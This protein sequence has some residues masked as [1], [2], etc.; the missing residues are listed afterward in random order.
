MLRS[1]SLRYVRDGVEQEIS[2]DSR[3]LR[4]RAGQFSQTPAGSSLYFRTFSRSQQPKNVEWTLVK[5]Y[6]Q[7]AAAF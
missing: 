1:G 6:L 3:R 4:P 2:W 5:F 7:T